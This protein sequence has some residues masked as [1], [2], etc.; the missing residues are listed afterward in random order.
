MVTVAGVITRQ[1]AEVAIQQ[2]LRAIGV[3]LQVHNGPANLL[4][5]PLGAGGLLASGKFDLAIYAW[6]QFPDPDASQTS[7]PESIP[8]HGAN[9]SGVADAELGRLQAQARATYDRAQRKKLYARIERR[10]GE[11]LPYHT[12]VWRANVNAWN[13]DLHNV[14]PAQAVSDFWNVGSW[15]L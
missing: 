14:K 6:T 13:E 8:P 11:V 1:N 2:Q 15:T 9:Y 12:I 7:G 4:F 10:L 5:A 3:D